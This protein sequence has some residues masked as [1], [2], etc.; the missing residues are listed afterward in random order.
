MTTMH[1]PKNNQNQKSSPNHKAQKGIVQQ[2][3]QQQRTKDGN[4]TEQP[5]VALQ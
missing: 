2:Q 5:D 3:K 1:N 4:H